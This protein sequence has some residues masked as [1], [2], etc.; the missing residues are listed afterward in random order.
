MT[1]RNGITGSSVG[2]NIDHKLDALKSRMIEVKDQAKAKSNAV[3][4]NATNLIK[5]HP[6]KA[7][8]IAFAAGYIGMRLLRR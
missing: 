3:L 7:V 6:L 2:A 4:E 8:A 1:P 5:A